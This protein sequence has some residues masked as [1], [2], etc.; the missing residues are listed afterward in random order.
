MKENIE[1]VFKGFFRAFGESFCFYIVLPAW[2][3]IIKIASKLN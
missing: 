1:Y 3:I 2:Y